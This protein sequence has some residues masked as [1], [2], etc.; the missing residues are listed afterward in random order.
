LR[1]SLPSDDVLYLR[2]AELIPTGLH[3]LRH[4]AAERRRDSGASVETVSAFLD[5]SSLAVTTVYLRRLEGEEDRTFTGR[6]RRDRSV[7]PRSRLIL[8]FGR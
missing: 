1:S 5:R 4:T 8:H 6:G 7:E 3:V 2:A